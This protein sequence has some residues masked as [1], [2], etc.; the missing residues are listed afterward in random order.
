MQIRLVDPEPETAAGVLQVRPEGVEVD[1]MKLTAPL[2]EPIAET[3]IVDVPL[4]PARIVEGA[5]DPAEIE[6]S[7]AGA[8][9]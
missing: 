7:G 1:A 5:A 3:V 4:A 9:L 6:K 2:K 8:T